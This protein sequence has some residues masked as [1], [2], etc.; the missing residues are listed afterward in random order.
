MTE[1]TPTQSFSL[2]HAKWRS[3]S[4]LPAGCLDFIYT[5][6]ASRLQGLEM[7]TKVDTGKHLGMPMVQCRKVCAMVLEP[8]SQG[9]LT[10]LVCCILT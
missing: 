6:K 5:T 2:E 7:M 1:L 8:V 4:L 3:V 9:L 10:H